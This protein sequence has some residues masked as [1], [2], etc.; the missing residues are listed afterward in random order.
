MKIILLICAIFAVSFISSTYFMYLNY[1][2]K[3]ADG[4]LSSAFVFGAL[5]SF[6]ISLIL[7]IPLLIICVRNNHT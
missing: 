3:A 4:A 6:S 1:M 2:K 5:F 7:S